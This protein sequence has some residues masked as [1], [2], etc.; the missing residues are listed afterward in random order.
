MSRLLTSRLLSRF[1]A[2]L[3]ILQAFQAASALAGSE[4]YFSPNGSIRDRLLRAINWAKATIDLAIFDLIS[5]ELAGALL[6]AK[7]RGVAIRI[8]ADTRQAQGKHSEIPFLLE[9]GVKVRLVRG[10]GRGIMH[11]KFAIFDGKLLVTGSYNWTDSA[12]RFNHENALVLDDSEIIRRYQ[13]RF[14]HLF[15]GRETFSV[16]APR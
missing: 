1:L 11:H 13:A 10:N 5:G 8:V 4:V 3:L 15:N 16:R 7:E 12:E 9:K 14:E 2:S 6:A